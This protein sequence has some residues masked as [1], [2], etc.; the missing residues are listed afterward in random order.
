MAKIKQKDLPVHERNSRVFS[1]R[2][3]KKSNDPAHVNAREI[4]DAVWELD[5]GIKIQFI[6]KAINLASDGDFVHPTEYTR[7]LVDLSDSLQSM[8][9]RHSMIIRELREEVASLESD[10]AMLRDLAIR[11]KSADTQSF[12]QVTT[13]MIDN[14]KDVHP[15]LADSLFGLLED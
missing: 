1:F 10:R 15:D 11:L 12:A 5:D 14:S 4:M 6:V 8:L 13:E 9:D 7:N 3:S 2:L